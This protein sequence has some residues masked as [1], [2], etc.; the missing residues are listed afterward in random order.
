MPIDGKLNVPLLVAQAFRS[1]IQ[2][3]AYMYLFSYQKYVAESVSTI[4]ARSKPPYAF[5]EL[6][7]TM[8]PTSGA[9]K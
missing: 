6:H 1:Q 5:S 8:V 3:Y 7:L 4:K 2:T 9:N